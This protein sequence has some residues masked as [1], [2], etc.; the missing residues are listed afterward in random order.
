MHV[1]KHTS[2]LN[3]L[4]PSTKTRDINLMILVFFCD[5]W[6]DAWIW[7]HWNTSGDMD[8][9]YLEGPFILVFFFKI[10]V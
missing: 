3:I 4:L 9:S 5:V 6:E 2:W 10:G 1:V 8:L 7:V